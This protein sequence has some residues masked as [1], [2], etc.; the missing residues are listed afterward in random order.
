[1]VQSV[2]L[3]VELP[4]HDRGFP[5]AWTWTGRSPGLK[6]LGALHELWRWRTG[7]Y[8]LIGITRSLHHS[9]TPWGIPSLD[10]PLVVWCVIGFPPWSCIKKFLMETLLNMLKSVR[11]MEGSSSMLIDGLLAS[12]NHKRSK[13]MMQFMERQSSRSKIV[14]EQSLKVE[15][16]DYLCEPCIDCLLNDSLKCGHKK[17]SNKYPRLSMLAK[18]LLSIC[19]SNS[20]SERLFSTSRGIITFRRG[21]LAPDTISAFM[22]LKSWSGED[23]TRDDEMDLEVEESRLVKW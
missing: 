6:L 22:T 8:L 14:D 3:T 12:R 4:I 2:G 5:L 20:S 10:S 9:S 15:L 1:M 16:D 18:E 21:R 23:A 19:A 7:R 17:G 11:I 13:V